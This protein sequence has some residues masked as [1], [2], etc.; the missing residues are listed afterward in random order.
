MGTITATDKAITSNPFLTILGF[1]AGINLS[2]LSD[3]KDLFGM[4]ILSVLP[5]PQKDSFM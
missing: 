5:G 4:E 2:P 3:S 1:Q